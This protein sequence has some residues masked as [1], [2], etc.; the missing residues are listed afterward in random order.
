LAGDVL[1]GWMMARATLA[2]QRPELID[3]PI[4]QTAYRTALVYGDLVLLPCLG[5]SK[6]IMAGEHAVDQAMAI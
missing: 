2:S 4:A 5:Q 1:G 3:N 6:L